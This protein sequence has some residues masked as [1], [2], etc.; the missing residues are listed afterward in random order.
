M[1]AP[2]AY[3]EIISDDHERARQ[4]YAELFGWT[5]ATDPSMG[6]Y[7]LMDTGNGDDAV[8]GGIGPASGQD[9]AGRA[10]LHARRRPGRLPRAGGEARRPYPRAADGS[11]E[12]LRPD[13]LVRRPGREH[14]R[15]VEL[16]DRTLKALAEPRRREILRLVAHDELAAGEIAAA[17]D[18]SRT[19]VSQ[20]LT[21]LKDADAAR[22]A[23]RR[24]PPA[25]PGPP[26]R[27]GRAAALPGRH[28]GVLAGHRPAAGRGRIRLRRGGGTPCRLN[29]S[30]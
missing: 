5:A 27:P 7:A 2:V 28:V 1:G 10:D 21:V 29:P 17:F 4:F 30:R 14:S 3:F 24:H 19:A 9:G 22:R 23:P 18:V 13:R 20:H 11:A 6:D 16:I 8:G 12:R 26:G 25:L 15:S